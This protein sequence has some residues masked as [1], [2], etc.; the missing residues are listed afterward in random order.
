MTLKV[1]ILVDEARAA[2][3]G[4]VAPDPLQADKQP[5]FEADQQVDVAIAGLPRL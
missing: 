5:L 1:L 4:D 2:L 3:V